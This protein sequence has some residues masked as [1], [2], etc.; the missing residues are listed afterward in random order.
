DYP[1]DTE[2]MRR[3]MLELRQEDP[4]LYINLTTGS[5]PSPFWLRYADSVWR[6]GD[7]MGFA[8]KGNL[9]QQWLTY[10]DQETFRNIAGKGPLFP[11]NALM[12]QGVA[13]SRRGR[14]GDP[15]FDSAGFKDDVRAFFGSGT[16]LQELYIQPGR[17]TAEN[18]DVLAEAARWSRAN[19]DVL[20]DTHWIGGDPGKLEVYG[21]ASWMPRKG[22]V[23]LR[24][25]DDRP[26]K[27]RM[28]VQLAF[29]LPTGAAAK[30]VFKSP[31]AED[32][33]KP[34]L[35]AEA[36]KPLRLA[37]KPFEVVVLEAAEGESVA[38]PAQRYL[39]AQLHVVRGLECDL[40]AVTDAADAAAARLLAGGNLWLAGEPGMIAELAG[41][42]GGLCGAKVLPAEKSATTLGRNDVV[43]WSDYGVRPQ[44]GGIWPR[45]LESDALVV[46]FAPE[47]SANLKDP[48]PEHV[49]RICVK[50]RV[51]DEIA[52]HVGGQRWIRSIVPAIA[53]AQWTF[54]AEL[55]GAVRRHHRQLAVYLSTHLDPGLRRFKRTNGLLLEPDLRPDPIERKE[56]GG[57]FLAMVR[58]GLEAIRREEMPRIRQAGVWL[59]ESHAAHRRI[60]RNLQ[61]HLPPC[62]VNWPGDAGFFSNPK[63][64]SLTGAEGE[65]WARENLRSGDIYLLLGYQENEDDVAA[66][67]HA[68]DARTIFITSQGPGPAQ[69]RDPHHL[70]INP[71]WP[72][73]DACLSL[74]G[75]DVKA[76]PL[77]A[78][79]GLSCYYAIC[80]EVDSHK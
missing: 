25:P 29:Q 57:R 30:F 52:E 67:A 2:A 80:E 64:I 8:G 73:S 55:L 56:Y 68:L 41:R 24:N 78:I 76:C 21:F 27:F 40:D 39:D 63:P 4:N 44:P 1:L 34:A 77:S 46:A 11:L 6:Q 61:G 48:L 49:R 31:W 60:L 20:V 62:E 72:R 19:A 26:Q 7:D 12:T 45:H 36:G 28:D 16:S 37:L 79:L 42:A 38:A 47:E 22:I 53:T 33:G 13:Y 54:V 5:W 43:L 17:L 35:P 69:G 58:D 23:M 66:A 59:T 71:H 50:T 70:H 65:R 18:W 3:L 9:Q 10:R 32:G 51:Q 14:A 15:S 75:Y 74:D